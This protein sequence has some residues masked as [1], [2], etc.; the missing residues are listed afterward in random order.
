MKTL[1]L[2]TLIL[3]LFA[4]HIISQTI[5]PVKLTENLKFIGSVDLKGRLPVQKGYDI[6][7]DFCIQ[8]FKNMELKISGFK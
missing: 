8:K 2:I 6:A 1:I 3:L 4:K 7:A 5:S